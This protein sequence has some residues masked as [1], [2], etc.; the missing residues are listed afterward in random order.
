[1][2][3]KIRRARLSGKTNFMIV[4][5]EGAASGIAVGEEIREKLGLDPRVTILGHIQRGGNASAKDRV[6]ATRMGYE[7]VRV[8][9]EGGT[10]RVIVI[11]SDQVTDLDIDEGL[12]MMKTL[13]QEEFQVMKT[14][15]GQ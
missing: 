5:A 10:N 9:A 7:A 4:V 11:H 6:M 14:M 8:L 13:N 12:A 3:A 15:T 1:M 2:E